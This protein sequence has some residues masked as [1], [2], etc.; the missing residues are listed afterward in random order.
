M[1]DAHVAFHSLPAPL[2]EAEASEK[3]EQTTSLHPLKSRKHWHK[4]Q[5]YW[6]S[7]QTSHK[8]EITQDK[9]ITKR[10]GDKEETYLKRLTYFIF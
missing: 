9:H 3:W 4:L 2:S 5:Y 7:F 8:D 6:N 1:E 10:I